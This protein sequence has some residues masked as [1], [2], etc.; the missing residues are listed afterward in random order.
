MKSDFLAEL[1]WR[2]MVHDM[3]PGAEKQLSTEMTSAYIGFD[4]TATSLHI[5]N[6]A[7]IMLLV[8]LQRSGHKPYALVGGATGMIGDPSFKNA[9]RKLLDEETLRIN[10]AGIEKQL[11]QF[12]DFDCGENSAE[13]VNN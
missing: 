6:L 13:I 2:G 4:P 5:G 9:E 12:L 7:T 8:H 1:R 11:E 10:Q 3:M